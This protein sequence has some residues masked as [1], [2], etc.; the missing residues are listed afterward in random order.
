MQT[1]KDLPLTRIVQKTPATKGSQKWLQHFVQTDPQALQPK[2]LPPLTWL[3]PCAEDDF[4]EYMDSTFLGKLNLDHLGPT[5][6]DFWPT[7]GPRWDGLARSGDKVVLVEAKAHIAEALTTPSAAT[8]PA[9]KALISVSLNRVKQALSADDRSDWS[10]CFY[11]YA[12]RI[13]HL[14]WLREHGVDAHLLFVGFVNAR[15]TPRPAS[16]ETW[17]TL[18]KAADHALG[19]SPAHALARYIHHSHPTP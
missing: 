13:A 2:T 8:S 19:L 18:Y 15:D 10:R 6:P 11:Q 9:S 12:N 3:S 5:L 1:R 16:A 14:W 4:A 7:S 17:Q